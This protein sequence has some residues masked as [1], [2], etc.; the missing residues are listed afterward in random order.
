MKNIK[1]NLPQPGPQEQYIKI[2]KSDDLIKICED[3]GN[4]LAMKQSKL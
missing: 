2:I 4:T 3:K 1:T